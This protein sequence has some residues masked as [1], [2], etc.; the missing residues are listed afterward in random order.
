MSNNNS[1]SLA[2]FAE[3]DNLFQDLSPNEES[4]VTGGLVPRRLI[5]RLRR[6]IRRVRRILHRIFW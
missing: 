3:S 1:D 2:V 6:R 4:M 5:R